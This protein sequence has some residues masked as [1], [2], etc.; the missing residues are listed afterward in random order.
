MTEDNVCAHRRLDHPSC[1]VWPDAEERR[2]HA[3]GEAS[4]VGGRARVRRLRSARLAC[5]K[6]PRGA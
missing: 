4:G 2:L 1:W 5:R 6:A 3:L